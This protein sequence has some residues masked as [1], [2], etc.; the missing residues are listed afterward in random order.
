MAS[1]PEI[2][3]V[4]RLHRTRPMQSVNKYI[5]KGHRVKE[6]ASVRRANAG[7]VGEEE[8]GQQGAGIQ[9]HSQR[10]PSTSALDTA[11]AVTSAGKPTSSPP[12]CPFA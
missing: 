1:G 8:G 10:P 12:T 7:R 5:D 6:T 4:D 2:R 11:V 9:P 3:I